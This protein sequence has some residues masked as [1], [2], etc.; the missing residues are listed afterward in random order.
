MSA[1][2]CVAVKVDIK[3]KDI[4]DKKLKAGL[5]KQIEATAQRLIGKQKKKLN[6]DPKCKDGWYL[7]VKVQSLTVDNPNKPT[8]LEAKIAID[9]TPLHSSG[10]GMKASA[11]GSSTSFRPNKVEQ[12][13][14]DL[15]DAVLDS[16]LAKKVLPQ[17]TK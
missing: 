8:K 13:A 4:F 5:V 6:Y 3:D 14:C 2:K 16:M 11:G 9:G 7:T 15:V 12:G 1:Q 10:N 17:M